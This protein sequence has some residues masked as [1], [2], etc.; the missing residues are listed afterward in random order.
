MNFRCRNGRKRSKNRK[1]RKFLPHQYFGQ[2]YAYASKNGHR[3]KYEMEEITRKATTDD[4]RFDD[5]RWLQKA[6]GGGSTAGGV[7][8]HPKKMKRRLLTY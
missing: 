8:A 2:V 1:A 7:A 4:A 6:Q 5:D 3:R